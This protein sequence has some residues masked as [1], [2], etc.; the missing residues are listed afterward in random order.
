MN[1]DSFKENAAIVTVLAD[2]SVSKYRERL[3]CKTSFF[4]LKDM[5]EMNPT[6]HDF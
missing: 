1:P 4:L 2:V 5:Y 6:D 3:Q